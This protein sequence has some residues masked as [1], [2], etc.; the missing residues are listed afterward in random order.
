MFDL[1][2]RPI[3]GQIDQMV[4]WVAGH[5]GLTRREITGECRQTEHVRARF[6]IMWAARRATGLSTVTIGRRLGGRD[7][8]TV[9]SGLRT[10]DKLRATHSEFRGLTD[11]LL[12]AFTP[13]EIEEHADDE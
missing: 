3:I 2:D 8:T 4:C 10:A 13:V 11:A 7:H 1:S 5:T 9:I 6:A 12:A